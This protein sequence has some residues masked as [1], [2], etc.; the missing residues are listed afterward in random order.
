MKTTSVAAAGG[1]NND[2][3]IRTRKHGGNDRSND[4]NEVEGQEGD[5][6]SGNRKKDSDNIDDGIRTK[7]QEGY[8]NR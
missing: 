1:D 2:D 6:N 4:Y 7:K 8:D 5:D 3:N